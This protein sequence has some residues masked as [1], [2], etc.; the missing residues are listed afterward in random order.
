MVTS[1]EC[2]SRNVNDAP[3]APRRQRPP[4]P[5]R[6]RVRPQADEVRRRLLDA[7]LRVFAERGFAEASIDEIASAAGFTKGAVYSQFAGKD[8][9]FFAL[10]TEQVS[11]RIR[12]IAAVGTA[13]PAAAGETTVEEAIRSMGARLSTLLMDS[14]PWQMLFLEFWQRAAREPE[15]QQRYAE[16]RTVLRQL[17]SAFIDAEAVGL[18]LRLPVSADDLTT[19]VLALC[20]G[21]FIEEAATPGTV[22]PGL[23]GD[24]LVR[25][26]VGP[27]A[28]TSA[29]R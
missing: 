25:L 8:D 26:L 11:E 27:D 5:P 16:Q 15:V 9:L 28:Q 18:G 23:L 7:A 29:A 4:R 22:R 2:M 14:R 6:L 19:L 24:V 3:R 12:L 17:I 10:F 1:I 20:N 13:D 21:L